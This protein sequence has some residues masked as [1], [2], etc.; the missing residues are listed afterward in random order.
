M[1]IYLPELLNDCSFCEY[2]DD[3]AVVMSASGL[4][5]SRASRPRKTLTLY[6]AATV[7]RLALF[8]RLCGGWSTMSATASVE[9]ERG[10]DAL[11]NLGGQKKG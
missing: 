6:L 2:A 1:N 10:S 5:N 11:V 8:T 7:F 3:S 9:T 4:F